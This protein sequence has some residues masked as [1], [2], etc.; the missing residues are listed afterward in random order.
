MSVSHSSAA[1]PGSRPDGTDLEAMR[2]EVEWAAERGGQG[3]VAQARARLVE[4]AQGGLG[5]HELAPARPATGQAAWA[6]GRQGVRVRE[7][8][9][10]AR[11]AAGVAGDI[12]ARDADSLRGRRR[13]AAGWLALHA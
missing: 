10:I 2:P 13:R 4:Q 7:K 11:K 3:P 9:E 8:H 1:A 12:R 5:G 6:G